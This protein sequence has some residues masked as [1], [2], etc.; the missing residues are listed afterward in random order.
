MPVAGRDAG[1]RFPRE[2]AADE[3][4]VLLRDR[5]AVPQFP[6]VACQSPGGGGGDDVTP[7]RHDIYRAF[8]PGA[9][10]TTATGLIHE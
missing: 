1:D 8:R 5:V 3:A 9:G 2:Q 4:R 6:V 7:A 10:G